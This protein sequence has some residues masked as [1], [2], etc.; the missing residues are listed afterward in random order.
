[1]GVFLEGIILE[2]GEFLFWF[3]CKKEKKKIIVHVH[4]A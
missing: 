1:L 2:L 3:A 4:G